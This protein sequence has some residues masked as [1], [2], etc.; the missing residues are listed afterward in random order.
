[1]ILGVLI[2]GGVF[3]L[4]RMYHVCSPCAG[5]SVRFLKEVVMMVMFRHKKKWSM[6]LIMLIE[7]ALMFYYTASRTQTMDTAVCEIE[8]PTL[9]IP[10]LE[11]SATG[12][13]AAW[14]PLKND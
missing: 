3:L 10:S 1:M 2:H 4:K 8:S 7:S 12:S 5:T 13:L 14:K 6:P 9:L 11:R